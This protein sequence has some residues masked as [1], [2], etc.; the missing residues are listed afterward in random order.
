MIAIST[1]ETL[2]IFVI[3]VSNILLPDDDPDYL[4]FDDYPDDEDPD[5]EY[6]FEFPPLPLEA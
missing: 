6:P 4:F 3:F 1:I 2:P 5:D